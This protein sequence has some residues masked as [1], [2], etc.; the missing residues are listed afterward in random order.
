MYGLLIVENVE[1]YKVTW[2]TVNIVANDKSSFDKIARKGD[3]QSGNESV[4][5]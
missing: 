1:L 5:N 4:F 3:V 2:Y